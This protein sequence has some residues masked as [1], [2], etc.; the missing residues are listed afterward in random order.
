M[1]NLSNSNDDVASIH[2]PPI[3]ASKLQSLQSSNSSVGSLTYGNQSQLPHLPIPTLEETI[4]RFPKVVEALQTKEQQE[5]TK[6]ICE[7]FLQGEGPVLQELLLK[8]EQEG[9]ASGKIGSYI[10]EFW[11][12]SYLAPDESVVMNLNPFF[13]L[14][15]GPDPKI[16]QDQLRRAASL[17]FASLKLASRLKRETLS[18]DVFKGKP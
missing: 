4:G 2:Q 1:S 3:Q 6:R 18:P 11:N 12:E 5:E 13:V 10:E 8:Y 17:C 15:G 9:V 7:E 14:E 16:A